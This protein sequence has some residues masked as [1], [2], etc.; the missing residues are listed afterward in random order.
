MKQLVGPFL[1]SLVLIILQ[2]NLL[3][4]ENK[5]MA[6]KLGMTV[7]DASVECN[8]NND[9]DKAIP[10][11]TNNLSNND[12][13]AKSSLDAV[14]DSVGQSF[15]A[16]ILQYLSYFDTY[17]GGISNTLV[18]GSLILHLPFTPFLTTN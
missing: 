12:S 5:A 3:T 14:K 16:G 1:L 2:L 11:L 10:S 18:H 6:V 13:C 17:I 9:D 15:Q 7:K 4:N 8:N